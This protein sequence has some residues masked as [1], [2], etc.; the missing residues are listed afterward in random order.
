MSIRTVVAQDAEPLRIF[1]ASIP[2]G[3]ARFLKEDVSD[4]AAISHWLNASSILK[5][6]YADGAGIAGCA[7]VVPGVGRS[8]H[9]AE[10]RL[11][12]DARRRR[13]GIG[14][15]LAQH[16]LISSVRAGYRKI[17]VEVSSTQFAVQELFAKLGFVPE[18]LFRDQIRAD[19]GTFTDIIVL[20]H[21][22]DEN[23]N[24]MAAVGQGSS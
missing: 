8:D 18:A 19:D 13:S 5:F 23:W 7:S 6:I 21:Q 12:V 11:V 9:V 10:L 2:E 17:T 20:S 3:D 22:V 4:P 1:I 15:L 14:R 24:A 16:A